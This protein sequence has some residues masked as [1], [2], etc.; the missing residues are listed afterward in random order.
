MDLPR[1]GVSVQRVVGRKHQV[2]TTVHHV[3]DW[4]IRDVRLE[5]SCGG[6][7]RR[8]PQLTARL[9]V[10]WDPEAAGCAKENQAAGRTQQTAGLMRARRVPFAS[11]VAMNPL[12]LS[13]LDIDR[14]ERHV[15]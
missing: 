10:G 3:R 8:V 13:G 7:N 14:A 2:L 6:G 11:R 1:Y 15:V 4:S 12:R 9:R 5:F